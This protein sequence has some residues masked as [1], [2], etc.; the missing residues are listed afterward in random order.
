MKEIVEQ[1]LKKLKGAKKVVF[2]GVGEEKLRDDAVSIYI[3][4]EL[5]TYS[6]EKVLF[7]NA[8]IDPMSRIEDVVKFQ[9]SHL[10]LIDTCT[11]NQPPGTIAIIERENIQELVPISSHTIPIHIV[12][13][14]LLE[15]LSDLEVFMIGIVPES[16]E[17]FTELSFY[18]ENE[19]SLNDR[20]ENED[21][22]FFELNLTPT[23]KKVADGIINLIKIIIGKI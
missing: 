10:I 16:L 20:T 15:R 17:G 21:L 11:L 9:P 18:K 2:M 3:I 23:I 12:I 8:G 5:L 7:I 13:D 14:L 4:S 19:Y 6:N 22:P 1:V